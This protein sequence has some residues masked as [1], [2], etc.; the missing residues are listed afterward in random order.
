[1]LSKS[2]VKLFQRSSLHSFPKSYVVPQMHNSVS[3][4]FSQ[5]NSG[6][7]SKPTD[8]SNLMPQDISPAI[9][10]KVEALEQNQP[11]FVF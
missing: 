2:F 6:G 3:F 4:N 8:F 11:F 7:S 10:E 9:A 5:I 1:M